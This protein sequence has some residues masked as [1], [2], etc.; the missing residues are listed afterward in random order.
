MTPQ[1]GGR[2]PRNSRLGSEVSSP[3]VGLAASALALLSVVV[4]AL[5]FGLP[6]GSIVAMT[7]VVVVTGT[8]G[9]VIPA[10]IRGKAPKHFATVATLLAFVIAISTAGTLLLA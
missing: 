6:I 9:L 8:L 7:A 10:W 5:S 3:G 2:H 1:K 4:Y